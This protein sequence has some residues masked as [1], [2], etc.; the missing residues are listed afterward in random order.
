MKLFYSFEN[1]ILGENT[2]VWVNFDK[3]TTGEDD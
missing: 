3:L 1:G 2:I